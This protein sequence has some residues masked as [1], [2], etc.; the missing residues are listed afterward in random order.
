M[1]SVIVWF[2]N[3]KLTFQRVNK[4][5]RTFS[6]P[7][8]LLFVELPSIP[9]VQNFFQ[10]FT[11]TCEKLKQFVKKY[12]AKKIVKEN[13]LCVVP[14]DTTA[15]EKKII[16][17]SFESTFAKNITIVTYNGLL[18]D[19]IESRMCISASQRSVTISYFIN[20]TEIDKVHL[21]IATVSKEEIIFSIRQIE[22]KF[23]LQGTPIFYFNLPPNLK[24]GTEITD[25]GLIANIR[26]IL[27]NKN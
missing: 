17:E 16:Y 4:K 15:N 24:I 5:Y 11:F 21:N 14:C 8:D 12:F 1:I 23:Q 20:A 27:T 25:G 22:S 10:D 6:G 19:S 7:E 9:Y 18:V 2:G 13:V 26:N 3:N